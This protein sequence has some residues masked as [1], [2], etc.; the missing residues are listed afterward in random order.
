MSQGKISELKEQAEKL[1]KELADHMKRIA[2][3]RPKTSD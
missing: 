2:A 3:N 1:E